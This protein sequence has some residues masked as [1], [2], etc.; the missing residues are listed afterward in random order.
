MKSTAVR[1]KGSIN[2]IKAKAKAT[3]VSLPNAE[4][5]KIKNKRVVVLTLS[6]FP[7]PPPGHTLQKNIKTRKH[8]RDPVPRN[9]YALRPLN[10]K[11]PLLEFPI[12][13]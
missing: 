8:I 13:S 11:R 6:P 2:T 1:A 4:L 9:M 12:E 7:H 3:Y 10:K 5:D